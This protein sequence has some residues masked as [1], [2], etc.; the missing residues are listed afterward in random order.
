MRTSQSAVAR[1]EAGDGN[2][3]LSTI[4][5]YATA[6]GLSID[7]WLKPIPTE[8]AVAAKLR[9]GAV[10]RDIIGSQPAQLSADT[11]LASAIGVIAR[12][13]GVVVIDPDTE[14][15]LGVVTSREA[16][17]AVAND[18]DLNRTALS[19]ICIDVTAQAEDPIEVA[20]DLMLNYDLRRLPVLDETNRPVGL[21]SMADVER[22]LAGVGSE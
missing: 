12:E 11:S 13:G 3:R 20:K 21:V 2:P 18:R 17:R 9:S 14:V 7:W 10:L 6:V 19:D 15:V 22:E 8:V 5:R 4:E 16:V 1:L